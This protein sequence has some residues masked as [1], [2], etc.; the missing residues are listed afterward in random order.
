MESKSFLQ[1]CHL[2]SI[3]KNYER[4]WQN[5]IESESWKTFSND[6]ILEL[7]DRIL[8]KI[9]GKIFGYKLEID[10]LLRFRIAMKINKILYE[11]KDK[12][13]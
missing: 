12:G 8:R 2:L 4:F 10:N 6:E 1:W 7:I 11:Y 5:L 3:S 13:E 9:D